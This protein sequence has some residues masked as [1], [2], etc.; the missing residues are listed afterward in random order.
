M[1]FSYVA[2]NPAAL[3]VAQGRTL[4][5]E[6]FPGLTLRCFGGHVRLQQNGIDEPYFLSG[7]MAY[8]CR[9][10]GLVLVDSCTPLSCIGVG[11]GEERLEPGAGPIRIRATGQIA[12]EARRFRARWLGDVLEQAVRSLARSLR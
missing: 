5:V 4:G 7:G 8:L 12:R 10:E 3:V 6:G 11:M 1:R 2:D 9:S